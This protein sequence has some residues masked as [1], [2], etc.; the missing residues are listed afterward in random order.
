LTAGGRNSPGYLTMGRGMYPMTG[1]ET[2]VIPPGMFA[3]MRA[4]FVWYEDPV[5]VGATD[6]ALE[7]GD[8]AIFTLGKFGKASGYRMPPSVDHPAGKV[9]M[10]KNSRGQVEPRWGLQATQQ[11]ALPKGDSVAMEKSIMEVN[12]KGGV[13][14]EYYACDRTG[15]G[16]GIADLMRNNWSTLIHDVNYSESASESKLMQEDSKTCKEQYGLMNTELWFGLRMWAEFGYLLLHPSLDITKLSSQVTERRFRT[17]S[18]KTKVE[19]KRDY[20][21]R[22]YRSPNEADSLT[23]LVLA[24]RKGSGLTLTM[25]GSLPEA[26]G[27]D[28][29]EWPGQIY[30][31][32]A[33]IDSSNKSDFL[34]ESMTGTVDEAWQQMTG[35]R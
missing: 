22:G 29:A 18:G 25:S 32:G 10:F 14:P 28:D 3:R 2:T 24:A 26:E 21:S 4:E 8:E 11:M 34:D 12:R 35:S 17:A 23:L 15:H 27:G 33:R 13:R 31:G 5:P 30:Q 20:M 7:G 6:L 1:L 19:A 9:V 16:A